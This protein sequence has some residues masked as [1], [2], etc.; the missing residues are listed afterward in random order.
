MCLR[1]GAA[2]WPERMQAVAAPPEALWLRGRKSLISCAPRI[3]I[4]GSR[5]PTPYGLA[6]AT[7]FGRE[8]A[9]AGVCVVSGLARGVDEAA[10][11]AALESGGATLA[12]LGCGVDRPWPAGPTAERVARDGLLVSEHPPGTPPRRHHFPLRNRILAALADAVLVVE[13]AHRSGSLITARWA[14]DQGQHVLAI[15]GRVDHPMSRGITRLIREGATPVDSPGMLLE[16]VYGDLDPF[17]VLTHRGPKLPHDRPRPERAPQTEGANALTEGPRAP[18]LPRGDDDF[19]S[20]DARPRDTELQATRLQGPRAE[21]PLQLAILRALQGETLTPAEVAERAGL[22]LHVTLAALTG[23][24]LDG[25]VRRGAG[26][27][28]GLTS[29]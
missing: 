14:A 6:Q 26:G 7:R 1:E 28:H 27:L 22:D 21:D 9:R 18:R 5:A 12:V 23:L 8:L 4:V 19:R 10:H 20:E 3:A 2:L 17:G 13:A 24:E 29:G 15:P 16:D 11:L 25:I